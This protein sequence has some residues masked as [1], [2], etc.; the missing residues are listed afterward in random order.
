[1]KKYISILK[2]DLKKES[3]ECIFTV[4]FQGPDAVVHACNPRDFRGLQF[5]AR[6]T[7]S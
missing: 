2:K 4:C 3:L 6:V 1:M 7:K 5:K